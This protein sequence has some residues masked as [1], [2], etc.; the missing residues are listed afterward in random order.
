MSIVSEAREK[1][2]AP[3]SSLLPAI[4][5]MA[6]LYFGREVFVP[7][8]LAALLSFLLVP[9]SALLERWGMRRTPAGLLV[10]FLSLVA[11][12][13]LGWV[14]L[15]Q[16]YNLAVELPQYKENINQKIESL[17]LHSAGRLSN[18]LAMLAEETKQLRGD[19]SPATT[20]VLP[21]APRPHIRNRSKTASE[22]SKDQLSGQ[23]DQPVTVRVEQ[24]EESVATLVNRTIAPLIH[25][26]TTTFVVVVFLAFMLVGREDLRDRGIRLAG[27][28]RM[29]VT[30]SAMEDAG[31]RVGRYL[32]M[33]LIVNVAFGFI[34]G[35]CLWLIGVP[36]PLL[37][38]LLIC[39]LRFVPFIGIFLAAAGPLFLSIAVSP[40]WGVV[41]WTALLFL[42]LELITGNIVEPL[43]YS[44]STGLSPIAVLIAAIFWTLLW[45]LPGLLLSTP[46]TVCLVVIGRQVPHLQYLDVLF[47]DETAL[48]PPERFYQR[49]LSSNNH[50]ARA[51]LDGL[52]AAKS[53]EL[54][55]DSVVIPVLTLIEESR[56]ARS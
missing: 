29:Q 44:S 50:E 27:R 36:N 5:V 22:P 25:P 9:V 2:K 16:I 26:L 23:T 10:V 47:G 38:G 18:T 30:T 31:R 41:L 45:G 37:W 43:L 51:L 35:S 12:T 7:L 28:G 24:P 33:Q 55:Y 20:T 14:M 54:V 56:H 11:V 13:A 48:P 8:A 46:L 49:L 17:H 6:T 53:K 21:D 4:L 32:R 40:H 52:F 3:D 34:A 39:L 15:G 19:A 42:V 1:L